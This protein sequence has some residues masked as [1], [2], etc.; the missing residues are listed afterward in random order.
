MSYNGLDGTEVGRMEKV[1]IHDLDSVLCMLREGETM[2]QHMKSNAVWLEDKKNPYRTNPN[3]SWAILSR[4]E[5]LGYI[6]KT[7]ES[8]PHISYELSRTGDR[9]LT[10]AERKVNAPPP[11]QPKSAPLPTP[12]Q[13]KE[14]KTVALIESKLP[15]LKKEA[16]FTMTTVDGGFQ[17][18]VFVPSFV[19]VKS[20][21]DLLEKPSEYLPPIKRTRGAAK[22]VKCDYCKDD[23][24]VKVIRKVPPFRRQCG[25]PNCRAG[26][27]ADYAVMKALKDQ[28]A[29]V[30]GL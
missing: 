25:K 15:A 30:A 11:P 20:I 19:Q 4:L 3:V 24:F 7:E 2:K 14:Q 16:S 21:I 28:G 5:H 10:S 8:Y 29:D 1:V 27:L 17:V 6:E 26:Y 12:T 13:A 9:Y 18:S 23:Y 22:A